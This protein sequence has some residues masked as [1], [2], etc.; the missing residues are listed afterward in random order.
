MTNTYKRELEKTERKKKRNRRRKPGRQQK[1]LKI[2]KIVMIVLLIGLIVA[3]GSLFILRAIGK[4]QLQDNQ[5]GSAADMQSKMNQTLN[6]ADAG[7]V[8]E[9]AEEPAEPETEAGS[10]EEKE[11]RVYYNGKTYEFNEDIMTFLVMGIDQH[12]ETVTEYTEGFEGGSADAIFLVVLNPHS[13]KL[14]IIAIDRNTMTDVDI[15]DYYGNYEET[16]ETQLCVQHGFG[17]GTV[18]SAA[19]M[20]KAVSNLLY[21]LPI[22]GYCAINMSAIAKIND[23]I[24]GVD[25]EV[26]E[27]LTKWDK[28]LRK[29]EKVHL[30]GKSAFL[31]VQRRDTNIFGSAEGRLERQRQYINAFIQKAKAEF[32]KNPA[33]PVTLYTELKPY[34][35]TDLNVEKAA[36][37]A[38]MA[39]GFDF[40]ATDIRKIEGEN[41]MGEEYEEFYIDEDAM[42][43]LLLDTFYEEVSD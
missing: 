20:E 7:E 36:Y 10:E 32:K 42:Y 24:G 17:D 15:Y 30:M 16:I 33:L 29:G 11:G 12:S 26:L 28:T 9:N 5:V 21:G 38:G 27:D 25:V 8:T 43:E 23:S 14:Q 1:L 35:T 3:I 34:M 39:A 31:Y 2:L 6:Q 4:K 22:N 41:V 13:K 18:K 37:L 40:H 19:Y